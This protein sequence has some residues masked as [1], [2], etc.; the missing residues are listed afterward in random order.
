MRVIEILQTAE[1]CNS[2]EFIASIT[3][4]EQMWWQFWDALIGLRKQ[5]R[6]QSSLQTNLQ[7]TRLFL[8]LHGLK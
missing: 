1:Q 4:P 7:L 6:I 5:L 2:A 3:I 8:V